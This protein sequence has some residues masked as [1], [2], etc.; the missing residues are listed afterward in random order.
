[1]KRS[2]TKGTLL[3][4]GVDESARSGCLQMNIF[5]WIDAMLSTVYFIYHRLAVA[6]VFDSAKV[7]E[8]NPDVNKP[9][10]RHPRA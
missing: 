7:K 9:I 2:S 8:Y 6:I 3:P 4:Q 10:C 5:K 1:M